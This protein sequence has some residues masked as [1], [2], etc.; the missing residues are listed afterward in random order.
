SLVAP[1]KVR[2]RYRLDGFD[3]DWVP[4]ENRRVAYY[5]NLRS[6][7]YTFRVIACNNHGVWN[8]QGDTIAF[9]LPPHFYQ[10]GLFYVMCGLGVII[11][12]Y[13]MHWVRL[14]VVRKI[15][16]LE[17]R[18]ALEKER[19][20]IASEM[21]DD[22][23]SSLTQI[24]LLSELTNR[25]LTNTER[26]GEHIRKIL[27]TTR[28]VFR[29]MDEIVWAINPKHDTLSSLVGYLS[30]YAQEFLRPA[31]VRCR[32]DLPAELPPFPLTTEERHNLFLTVKEALNNIA[33]HAAAS[34]VWLRAAVDTGRCN[35][36]I[37]DNGRG[38][39]VASGRPDGNGL[40]NM[41]NRLAAIGGEFR[42]DSRPGGGTKLEL[43][44]PLKRP[45][46]K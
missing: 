15:E 34:E 25:D 4:A 2:F 29:A 45:L 16:R 31:G 32:L 6:G 17:R 20:R 38:F 9:Y 7:H 27:A 11:V 22:L 44:V 28:A 21:H 24:A 13:G 46:E 39:L 26:A 35:I 18:H 14:R 19:A 1:E 40:R 30:N 41:K 12:G 36:S 23:G 8:F 33:K 10:T 43:F 37:E 5:T 42:L 3:K